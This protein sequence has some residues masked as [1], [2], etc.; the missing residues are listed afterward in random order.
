M[1]RRATRR[2]GKWVF[3]G[4]LFAVGLASAA[5]AFARWPLWCFSTLTRAQ[6][7]WSGIRG[8]R[9]ALD[10]M[11]IHYLEGGSGK[12]VVFV[13]GLGG[14]AQ[15][16]APLL[17][18]VVRGGF[19][20]YAMDLPGYG[21]SAAPPGR[22]YSIS[23]QARFVGSFLE[24]MHTGPVAL[25]GASM[26]GWISAAVA[27][28]A[29]Q[30]VERLV[31]MDSAGFAFKPDF[32]VALFTPTTPQEVDALLALISPQP[33]PIPEFV[34]EDVIRQ[35][36]GRAWVI[37]RALASMDAGGDVLDSR[38]SLLKV[39]VLLV[40]GKQDRITPLWLGEAMHRAAP[41][42]VLEVY[43]GCGHAFEGCVGRMAPRLIDFLNGHGPP[44]GA[45]LEIAAR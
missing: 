13:H 14:D 18:D 34:K 10:G 37:N 7:A 5:G 39:P 35:S 27:L 9:L 17:L 16:W 41:Q 38:F 15:E 31:L 2:H 32:N 4:L 28:D 12:P 45:A 23:E 29:P 30:R 40:W 36:R 26:G 25:V 22:S 43:D 6:L 19:R 33:N 8:H 1:V 20:V 42:S 21:E 3:F 24:A 11:D 44:A